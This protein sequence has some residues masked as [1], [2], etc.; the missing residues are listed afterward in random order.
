MLFDWLKRKAPTP[1]APL[2]GAPEVR[3][4]KTYQAETGY[5]YQ[6]YYDGWR[7]VQGGREF[8][9]MATATR[10]E[11]EAVAILIPDE[12]VSAWESAR[13]R[14]LISSEQHAVAKIALFGAFDSNEPHQVGRG[15]A[16]QLDAARVEEI[17]DRLGRG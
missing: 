16:V 5:V 4:L 8:V 15:A 3:R 9:F 14:E 1:L 17:L 12:A 7:P 10:S 2:R 11:Y 13:G 6:Y